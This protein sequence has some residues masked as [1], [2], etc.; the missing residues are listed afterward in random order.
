MVVPSFSGV[1]GLRA[2]NELTC[3]MELSLG[4]T[5]DVGAYCE[6]ALKPHGTGKAKGRNAE[7]PN[8]T[9]EIWLSGS[10]SR[11]S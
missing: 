10:V 1:V 2:D 3:E 6:S 7:T 4:Q 5:E 8:R 9:R 11:K